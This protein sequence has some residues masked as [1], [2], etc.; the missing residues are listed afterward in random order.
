[1]CRVSL[2]CNVLAT[3]ATSREKSTGIRAHARCG[4]GV[5]CSYTDAA[6]S[7]GRDGWLKLLNLSSFYMPAHHDIHLALVWV[8]SPSSAEPMGLS[9]DEKTTFVGSSYKVVSR[10]R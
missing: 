6:L 10:G 9:Y 5:S 4:D 7:H 1:M 3:L 2:A 8:I